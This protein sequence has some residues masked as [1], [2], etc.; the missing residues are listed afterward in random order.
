MK[1]KKNKILNEILKIAWLG[2]F[3]SVKCIINL[4]FG[5]RKEKSTVDATLW[6]FSA[7]FV[8]PERDDSVAITLCDLVKA[9]DCFSYGT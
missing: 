7:I 6:F 4:Q 1:N 9:F 5:F 8:S 3:D 2:F